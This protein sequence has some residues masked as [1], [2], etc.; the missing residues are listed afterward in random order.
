[1]QLNEYGICNNLPNLL[2]M[3]RLQLTPLAARRL[4]S[5][6]L[7]SQRIER[8]RKGFPIAHITLF[9]FLFFV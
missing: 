4:D 5:Y 1:M 6:P 2:Y 3:I 8:K 7:G 9:F